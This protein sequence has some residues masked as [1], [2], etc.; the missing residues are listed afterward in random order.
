M[1]QPDWESVL[2]EEI[3]KSSQNKVA[4]KLGVSASMV[5]QALKGT[6]P[7]NLTLLIERVEGA[8]MNRSCE[9]P[10]LGDIPANECLDHQ[11][12]PFSATNPQRVRIY[13]ACRNGCTHSHLEGN[14]D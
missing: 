3:S 10:V 9:C 2:R 13:R 1:N 5:S 4:K 11:N 14:H 7:G 6:Y 12:R 8:F